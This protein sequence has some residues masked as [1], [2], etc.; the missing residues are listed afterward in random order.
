MQISSL[1]MNPVSFGRDKGIVQAHDLRE[2][3]KLEHITDR[4]NAIVEEIDG[5]GPATTFEEKVAKARLKIGQLRIETKKWDNC[6]ESRQ[7]KLDTLDRFETEL[8]QLSQ[9]QESVNNTIDKDHAGLIVPD[10]LKGNGSSGLIVDPLEILGN[11][12]RLPRETSEALQVLNGK[13]KVTSSDIPTLGKI[14]TVLSPL[15]KEDWDYQKFN[16]LDSKLFASMKGVLLRPDYQAEINRQLEVIN[17]KL[18]ELKETKATNLPKLGMKV[19]TPDITGRIMVLEAAR[20]R[21]NALNDQIILPGVHDNL[22]KPDIAFQPIPNGAPIPF[23]LD[24][25][26]VPDK[27]EIKEILALNK[28]YAPILKKDYPEGL[29]V[30]I[31]PGYMDGTY[32]DIE[33]GMSIPGHPEVGVWLNSYDTESRYTYTSMME[34]NMAALKGARKIQPSVIKGNKDRAR[35][36]AHEIGHVISYN[37]MQ[38]PDMPA[39]DTI[40]LSSATGGLDFFSGWQALRTGAEYNNHEKSRLYNRGYSDSDKANLNL[41]VDYESVAED[42]RMAITGEQ[43]PASSKMTGIYDQSE[44]GKL[45]FENAQQYIKKVLLENEDPAIAMIKYLSAA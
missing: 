36:L 26:F 30:Y 2:V 37:R 35:A 13:R 23:K 31:V 40:L 32:G 28:G 11:Y 33:G 39:S 41:F 42:I 34:G 25:A 5:I 44:K 29:P 3:K 24:K 9:A 1:K 18:K 21:R 16:A 14:K 22:D 6:A 8:D 20:L 38:K 15:E 19:Y 4:V 17:E 7:R 10:R 27:N 45:P 43:I 12:N